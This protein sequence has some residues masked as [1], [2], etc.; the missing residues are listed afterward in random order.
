MKPFVFA[1]RL[2]SLKPWIGGAHVKLITGENPWKRP[3]M[4]GCGLDDYKIHT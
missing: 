3:S 1:Y 2:K 4:R